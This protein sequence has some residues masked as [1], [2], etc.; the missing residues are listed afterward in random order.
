MDFEFVGRTTNNRLQRQPRRFRRY[1]SPMAILFGGAPIG[2]SPRQSCTLF[3]APNPALLRTT[4]PVLRKSLRNV[5]PGLR[6][7][8]LYQNQNDSLQRMRNK[9][10]PQRDYYVW[11]LLN[12]IEGSHRK[13]SADEYACC[14]N[15]QLHPVSDMTDEE[16]KGYYCF[17]VWRILTMIT[18]TRI[19]L[20]TS[21]TSLET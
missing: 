3:D 4:C 7:L 5:V 12:S 13:C 10:R 18:R 2:D 15:Q 8:R 20:H 17:R 9:E 11:S 14:P 19:R 6:R 1:R 21:T 16:Y